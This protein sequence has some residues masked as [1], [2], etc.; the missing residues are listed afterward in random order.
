M[1]ALLKHQNASLQE[2]TAL[3]TFEAL[4]LYISLSWM[5]GITS[6][7]YHLAV[8]LLKRLKSL[9]LG[10]RVSQPLS[11]SIHLSPFLTP[12]CPLPSFKSFSKY[13]SHRRYVTERQWPQMMKPGEERQACENLCVASYS[14][15]FALDPTRASLPGLHHQ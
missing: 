1:K 12:S 11:L 9:I 6:C 15:C 13:P 3:Q 5:R 14:L 4:L 10:G 8:K 7:F 2:I